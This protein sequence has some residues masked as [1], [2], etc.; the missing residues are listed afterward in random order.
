MKRILPILLLSWFLSQ[1]MNFS[2]AMGMVKKV[3]K[4]LKNP[5]PE[6]VDAKKY[7]TARYDELL[8]DPYKYAFIQFLKIAKIL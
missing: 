1:Q 8:K 7:F 3:L 2:N 6:N 5:I 4:K